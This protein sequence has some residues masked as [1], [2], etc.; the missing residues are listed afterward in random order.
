MRQLKWFSLL[1]AKLKKIDTCPHL[2]NVLKINIP[3]QWQQVRTKH[4]NKK[5][6]L[7]LFDRS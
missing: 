2:F 7:V 5:T 6:F 1:N 4:Q 3:F